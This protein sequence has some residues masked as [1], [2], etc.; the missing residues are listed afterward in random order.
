MILKFT[1]SN[2]K[3]IKNPIVFDLQCSALK[4]SDE[5]GK[6]KIP[7][8]GETCYKKIT[9]IFG[10]NASGKSNFVTA[11]Y[12]MANEVRDSATITPEDHLIYDPFLFDKTTSTEPTVFSI[13]LLLSGVRYLYSFSYKDDRIFSEKLQ[14]A[15]NNYTILVF[16]RQGNSF[17]F[18]NDEKTLAPLV[19]RTSINKLFV[20]TA[21]SFNYEPCVNLYRFF[22]NDLIVDFQNRIYRTS[23]GQELFNEISDKLLKDDKFRSFSLSFLQAADLNIS[24]LTPVPLALSSSG[25]GTYSKTKNNYTLMVGHKAGGEE[26]PLHLE[27]ESDGTQSILFL[28]YF[29]YQAMAGEKVLIVDELDQSLHTLLL[30]FLVKTFAELCPKSQFVFTTH[31]SSIMRQ[32]SLRRDEFYFA[33]KGDDGATTLFPLSDFSVRKNAKIEDEYLEGRFGA[34]PFI[35]DGFVQ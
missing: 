11:L 1:A 2:F 14:Y 24:S 21:S 35:K 4:D 26:Y 30:P 13:E 34:I 32:C 9:A 17:K 5:K 28:S 20:G 19:N 33:D 27:E 18:G 25:Q 8:S 3:S 6:M 15:P 16:D 23:A 29:Y 12:T 22:A 10:A 7:L 31:D